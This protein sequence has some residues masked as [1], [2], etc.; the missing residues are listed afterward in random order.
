MISAAR[1]GDLAKVRSL[2]AQ[3]KVTVHTTG[4]LKVTAL[5]AA[6]PSGNVNLVQFLVSQGSDVNV[7]IAGTTP[8]SR[9]INAR[10]VEMVKILLNA[11][12]NPNFIGKGQQPLLHLA[13]IQGKPEIVALLLEHGASLKQKNDLGET[14]L[15][16]AQ[17]LV[18]EGNKE[19]KPILDLL[20]KWLLESQKKYVKSWQEK[21]NY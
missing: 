19:I 6:I 2:L 17:R 7:N 11:G 21:I 12:A 5:A 20:T 18:E 16:Y 1:A 13:I 8:L 10:S 15:A 14:L 4:P 3:G 9:A